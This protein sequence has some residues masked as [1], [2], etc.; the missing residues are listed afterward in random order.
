MR[1]VANLLFIPL[2]LISLL[3]F[4][5]HAFAADIRTGENVHVSNTKNSTQDLYLF[6]ERIGLNSATK[7]DIVALGGNIELNGD[8][9]GS[10]MAAGGTIDIRS[11]ISG[12]IRAAGG[13][14]KIEGKV[15]KDVVVAGGTVILT[16]TASV[17]G[18]LIFLGGDLTVD[19][20]VRGK[21][22]IRGGS[23]KIHSDI[24]KNVEGNVG[25]L[26]LGR[27]AI[28]HGD[29]KYSSAQEAT[30]QEGAF[31]NGD[32]DFK[33]V[34]KSKRVAPLIGFGTLYKLFIDIIISFLLI[35]FLKNPVQYMVSR[36]HTN[37]FK[38][39]FL[40]LGIL[41]LMPLVSL[42]LLVLLLLGI[43]SLLLY[44]LL[45]LV[46]LFITKLFIGFWILKWW[47][48]RNNKTYMLD[49]KAAIAGPI[50]MLILFSIPLI[51]WASIFVLYLI[52]LGQTSQYIF[53][54]I[55][56]EKTVL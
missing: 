39:G 31:I 29:L 23:A 40:G 6:G 42:L 52:S 3:L 49:Y 10:V 11:D 13:T 37:P 33:K 35:K 12:S 1:I 30:I 27:K 36:M 48:T 2:F 14:I 44:A 8:V 25:E 28:I 24:G 26:T 5:T 19:G 55:R 17:E 21:V 43:F 41:V 46:S 45:T 38:K 15:G 54:F 9:S 50:G 56:N 7:S 53:N 22:Y 47:E 18:D 51:G 32:H 4:T 34:E 16:N 20:P